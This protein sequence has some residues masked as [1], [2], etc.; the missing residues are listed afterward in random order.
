MKK[1]FVIGFS[2]G[3]EIDN[4]LEVA[5]IVSLCL[6]SLLNLARGVESEKAV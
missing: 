6:S 1:E 2:L 4:A 5:N 3:K